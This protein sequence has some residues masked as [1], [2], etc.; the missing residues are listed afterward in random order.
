MLLSQLIEHMQGLM[1]EHGDHEVWYLE[2]EGDAIPYHAE[3]FVFE[4]DGF[5]DSPENIYTV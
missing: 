3:W 5:G 4:P 1:S 2:H